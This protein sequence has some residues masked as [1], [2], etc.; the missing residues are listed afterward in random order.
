MPLAGGSLIFLNS[1]KDTEAFLLVFHENAELHNCSKFNE[2]NNSITLNL[3]QIQI[4]FCFVT[5]L[6]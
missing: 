6:P 3:Q 5:F 4:K 1:R 2:S